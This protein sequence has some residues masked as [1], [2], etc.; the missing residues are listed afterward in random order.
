MQPGNPAEEQEYSMQPG[1]PALELE[2]RI[3]PGNPVLQSKESTPSAKPTSGSLLATSNTIKS[4]HAPSSSWISTD[5]LQVGSSG[6]YIHYIHTT[7]TCCH[8]SAT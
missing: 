6:F 4:V 8:L 2:Y 7:F 3:Q 5:F 1:N